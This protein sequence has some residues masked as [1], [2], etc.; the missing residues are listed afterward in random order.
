[1]DVQVPFIGRIITAAAAA[2][3]DD[4]DDDDDRHVTESIT[5]NNT[6]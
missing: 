1:M 5:I 6:K 3:D 4:D 2:D